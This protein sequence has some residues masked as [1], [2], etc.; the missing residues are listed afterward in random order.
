M[1]EGLRI[2]GADEHPTEASA[3]TGDP[4][5]DAEI[6]DSTDASDQDRSAGADA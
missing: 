4:V 5:V 1:G 2:L 6:I 3:T